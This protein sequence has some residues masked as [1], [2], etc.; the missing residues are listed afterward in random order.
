MECVLKPPWN[1]PTPRLS[2]KEEAVDAKL[3][4]IPA[5]YKELPTPAF[6]APAAK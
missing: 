3:F 1:L 2:V 6:D 4:E 5:D